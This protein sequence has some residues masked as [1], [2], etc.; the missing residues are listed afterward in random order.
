MILFLDTISPSPKISVIKN[1]KVIHSIHIIKEKNN[2]I[3]DTIIPSFAK[4]LKKIKINKKFTKL[5]VCTGPGSYTSLRIGIAFMYGLSLSKNIPLA[6]IPCFELFEMSMKDIHKKNPTLMLVCSI[7]EQYFY[8]LHS[9]N[10]K[11]FS[12]KKINPDYDLLKLKNNYEYSFSNYKIPKKL[13]KKL[14]LK[15]HKVL[16]LAKIVAS[17]Y[18]IIQ[19]INTNK[20]IEPIYISDNKILN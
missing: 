20:I 13:K 18:K 5:L 11:N 6:G 7:F 9:K 12:I 8:F 3:S 16:D 2:K 4:V 19:S 10:K 1:N 15:K 14:G 17:N